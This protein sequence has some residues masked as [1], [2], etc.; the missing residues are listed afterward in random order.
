MDEN[1]HIKENQQVKVINFLNIKNKKTKKESNRH[2]EK[3]KEKRVT[4][5]IWN[6]SDE[7]YSYQKQLETINT[8]INNNYQAN[9]DSYLK[10]MISQIERKIYG[11]KKQDMEKN[12]YNE[13][14]FVNLTEIIDKIYDCSLL[15]YYCHCEMAI[16]YTIVREGCQWTIDRINNDL[17]H[18]T[19]NYV[20][21]CLDCNLK[22]RCRS[23]DKFLF[24]KQLNLVKTEC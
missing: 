4:T 3:K 2:N 14:K 11:Y 18:N 5:Y 6:F 12:I 8:F 22:R 17:G 10:T 23:S 15:C 1:E 21:A 20:L 16:L 19:D 24:T 13:E 7:E 9:K